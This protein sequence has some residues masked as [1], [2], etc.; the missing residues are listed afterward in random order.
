MIQLRATR[1]QRAFTMTCMFVIPLVLVFFFVIAWRSS[2]SPPKYVT[3]L[4]LVFAAVMAYSYGSLATELAIENSGRMKSSSLLSKK[5]IRITDIR[6]IDIRRWN[7][8]FIT[9]RAAGTRLVMY[10]DMPGAIEAMRGIAK[11]N[12]AI[13]LKE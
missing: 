1:F 9:V 6:S 10:R 13:E 2:Q 5:S 8:G 7:R 4:L 3:V 12:P 11:G